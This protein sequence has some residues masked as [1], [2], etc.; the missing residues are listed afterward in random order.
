MQPIK[1]RLMTILL[2][3]T[4]P[5]WLKDMAN[6]YEKG[7]LAKVV[8]CNVALQLPLVDAR[9]QKTMHSLIQ[10]KIIKHKFDHAWIMRL[11]DEGKVRE[12]SMFESVNSYRGYMGELDIDGVAG[13]STLSKYYNTV[14][15]EFPNWTFSDKNDNFERLRRINVARCFLA[16]FVK[17]T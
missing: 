17:G 12:L 10:N 2:D 6:S 8:G 1:E 7:G 5:D 16:A 15:G 14:D 4:D 13:V 11:I 9:V 3:S